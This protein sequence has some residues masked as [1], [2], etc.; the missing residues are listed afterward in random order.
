MFQFLS[1]LSWVYWLAFIP[2]LGFLVFVHELGHFLAARRM[3]NST[4]RSVGRST[5]AG[6]PAF[7]HPATAAPR[8][9]RA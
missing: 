6:A 1:G 5:R 8:T 2:V 9:A 4:D 7:K 3:G